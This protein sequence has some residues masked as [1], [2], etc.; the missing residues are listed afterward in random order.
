MVNSS[1]L[2]VSIFNRALNRSLRGALIILIGLG[3]LLS[4]AR[5][6]DID[7]MTSARKAFKQ[8]KLQEAIDIYSK[9]PVSSDFWL[10]SIEE[11]AWAHTRNMNYEKALGDLK[12]VGNRF[13]SSQTGPETMMLSAFVSFKI[14]AFKDVL[15]KV[16]QFKSRMHPR[17]ESLEKIM[18]E[19]LSE[20]FREAMVRAAEGK[21]RMSQLGSD[22]EKYPRYFYRD[23]KLIAASL[24]KDEKSLISRLR[25]LASRDLDEIERNL[26]KMKILEV[27]VIQRAFSDNK[28]SKTKKDLRFGNYDRSSQVAFP[29]SDEEIWVDE[30]GHYEVK[31]ESCSSSVGR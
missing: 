21:L 1:C 20:G 8:N 4:Q 12:S 13:W 15:R 27:E 17:V 7:L 26:K 18:T 5:A 29:V 3:S 11:R 14:C 19:P 10:D 25:F 31:A 2:K 16:D 28:I 23:H 22:A 30:V 6:S 9:V 24:A